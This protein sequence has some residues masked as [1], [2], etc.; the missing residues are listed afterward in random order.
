MRGETGVASRDKKACTRTFMS[1]PPVGGPRYPHEINSRNSFGC[2]LGALWN[3]IC[4]SLVH[5]IYRGKGRV[6][7]WVWIW[8]ASHCCEVRQWSSPLIRQLVLCLILRVHA[9]TAA[10]AYPVRAR[11]R[12]RA[13][14]A[15]T[16]SE[17][18]EGRQ[19]ISTSDSSASRSTRADAHGRGGPAVVVMARKLRPYLKDSLM[20]GCEA[21][22]DGS[23]NT[24]LFQQSSHTVERV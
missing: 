15:R 23:V 3:P 1:S 7:G 19:P 12:E 4:L 2:P 10:L 24:P 16:E 5:R 20:C 21:P 18:A 13:L 9:W 8:R 14:V 17:S 6:F 11:R 22:G